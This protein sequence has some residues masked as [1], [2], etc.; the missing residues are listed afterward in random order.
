M[1]K[2]FP[3]ILIGLLSLA[4][5]FGER[6]KQA[7]YL[8]IPLPDK[9]V[10]SFLNGRAIVIE[11]KN[12]L[13]ECVKKLDLEKR[14]KVSEA[15]A[16]KTLAKNV[17][18]SRQP[19]TDFIRV[20]VTGKTPEEAE[21]L[22]GG[23]LKSSISYFTRT[24]VEKKHQY[25]SEL[26]Q[27]LTEQGDL[28]QD[29]RKAVAVLTQ[30]YGVPYF[31]GE[32]NQ[33]GQTE[34][35]LYQQ[36]RKKLA[37]LEHQRNLAQIQIRKLIDTPNDDLIRLAAGLDLPNNQ[38]SK[39]YQSY[40]SLSA[41]IETLHEEGL[42]PNHPKVKALRQKNEHALSIAGKQ[43]VGIKEI[44]ETNLLLIDKKLE[45]TKKEVRE[46]KDGC[47]DL[48]MQQHQ[49]ATAIQAYEAAQDLYEKMSRQQQE[50][51]IEAKMPLSFYVHKI[52]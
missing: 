39:Y 42:A 28:I 18:A 24:E 10:D 37:E 49:Y 12:V 4:S 32:G 5:A 40:L 33:I 27:Q 7:A 25:L 41:E 46:R 3:L 47:V 1:V 21:V 8:E 13:E 29:Y 20:E 48:S 31:E 22:L 45:R 16:I 34:M 2:L 51:R 50:L 11:S 36:S 17:S 38:V 9:R 15:E 43:V 26:N 44:L 30:Q 19:D 52:P 6:L 23:I 14:W 35:A